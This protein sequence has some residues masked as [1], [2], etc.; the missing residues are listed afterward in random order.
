MFKDLNTGA[1]LHRYNT[2]IA[3]L[4]WCI[5]APAFSVKS[6]ILEDNDGM[7]A[8]E[9]KALLQW[10]KERGDV[11]AGRFKQKPEAAK[12]IGARTLRQHKAAGVSII[13]TPQREENLIDEQYDG[14]F[15]ADEDNAQRGEETASQIK[16]DGAPFSGATAYT[17]TLYLESPGHRFG[18][19][20]KSLC[21][22]AREGELVWA[23]SA[24]EVDCIDVGPKC[25]F[26][27]PAL[28][29]AT[30]N[31]ISVF[32]VDGHGE[33]QAIMES[34]PMRRSRLHL[35]QASMILDPQRRL[36]FAR[37]VVSGKIENSRNV[38]KRWQ[39]NRREA[40]GR[41]KSA[42]TRER[43]NLQLSAIEPLLKP[44]WSAAGRAKTALDIPT[45]L[46]F[47]GEAAKLAR[48]GMMP[49]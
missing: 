17:R 20:N 19:L 33:T 11:E 9:E 1:L 47:E 34:E 38:L 30:A 21:V 27:A 10:S 44:L 15:S 5:I 41:S 48:K 43:I 8:A 37:S 31:G 39:R 42:Q 6:F 32:M 24:H 13:D 12:A 4:L 29:L 49:L 3:P 35:Q 14:A 18:L 28:R 2:K 40:L 22:R 25:D 45:L 46:G 36:E 16:E 23:K 7:D 26:D